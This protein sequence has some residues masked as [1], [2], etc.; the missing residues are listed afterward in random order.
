MKKPQ[1]SLK[2]IIGDAVWHRSGLARDERGATAVEF[3]LLALPFFTLIAA[4]LETAIVFLASQ[5]LDSAVQDSA[6]LIR[7]GQ[8]QFSSYTGQM[9]KDAVCDRLFGLFDCTDL[10]IKVSE[11]SDFA[12]AT[13]ADEVVDPDTGEWTLVEDYNGGDGSSIML[14]EAYYKWPTF[15]NILGLNFASMP[16]GTVL[17]GGVR[18]FR[19][20]PYSS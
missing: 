9:Y 12:T 7:T 20:E 4:I 19:N 2:Q 14:V 11:L 13:T 5:V 6:R 15:L 1:R 10:K 17:L 8:A 3:G 16:D 18:V